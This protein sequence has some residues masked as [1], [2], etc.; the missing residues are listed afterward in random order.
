MISKKLNQWKLD[1]WKKPENGKGA[2]SS[3][4]PLLTNNP[5]K[6]LMCER[7]NIVISSR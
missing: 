2:K 5:T 1:Q 7:K 4:K 3:T 6:V